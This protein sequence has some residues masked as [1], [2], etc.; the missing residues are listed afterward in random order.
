LEKNG[1]IEVRQK[2]LTGPYP[3]L[4]T[5]QCLA[6]RHGFATG[7]NH[8]PDSLISKRRKRHLNGAQ[9]LPP[10]YTNPQF[11]ECLN[12]E[13]SEMGEAMADVFGGKV[14]GRYALEHGLQ[15]PKDLLDAASGLLGELCEN[16]ESVRSTHPYSYE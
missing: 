1:A 4:T 14:F 5:Y 3:F 9:S 13:Q 11:K 16:S 7:N 10:L 2:G 12:R 15:D 8:A 6:S